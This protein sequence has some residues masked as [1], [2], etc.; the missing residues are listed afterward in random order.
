MPTTDKKDRLRD[1]KIYK[2]MTDHPRPFFGA[3][4]QA[5]GIFMILAYFG[6]TFAGLFSIGNV[7]CLTLGAIQTWAFKEMRKFDMFRPEALI[8][9]LF[10]ARRFHKGYDLDDNSDAPYSAF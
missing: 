2:S 1:V 10:I 3:G 5:L 6:C 7:I 4:G 8:T 9:G